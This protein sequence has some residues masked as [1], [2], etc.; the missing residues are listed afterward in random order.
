MD[1]SSSLHD[2]D[3]PVEASP[4][5]S[6][7]APSPQHNRSTFNPTPEA[8]GSPVYGQN[9]EQGDNYTS[10][11]GIA[12]VTD[13]LDEAGNAHA[14]GQG[15]DRTASNAEVPAQQSEEQQP[16]DHSEQQRQAHPGQDA[17][18]QQGAPRPAARQGPHYK[19]QA[20]ITGLERVG[21]KDPILRFD[22]HV[23]MP[24]TCL[25]IRGAYANSGRLIFQLSELPSFV[26]C[27]ALI[28]SL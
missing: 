23:R 19:L 14:Y 28:R 3:N 25:S 13:M 2:G 12:G 16:T 9:R 6:S 22:V 4:W 8:P 24:F 26:M 27:G 20:K 17:Q 15:Q 1:Y 21:R 10:D 18:R 7:P 5:G 11:S